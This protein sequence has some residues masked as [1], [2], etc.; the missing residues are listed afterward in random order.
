MEKKVGLLGAGCLEL[1]SNG[2]PAEGRASQASGQLQLAR[3]LHALRGWRTA[4]VS[5]DSWA[6]LANT[7]ERKAFLQVAIERALEGDVL[8]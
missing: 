2:L 4:T 6:A 3:R 7:E 8:P 1:Y 5:S